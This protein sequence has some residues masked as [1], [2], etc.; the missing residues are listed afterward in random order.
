MRD[1]ARATRIFDIQRFSVHDGPGIRTTVFVAGCP[2][3]CAWCQNPE[4]FADASRG[5]PMTPEEVLP[6]LLA[7]R[8]YYGEDGGVTVSGGEPMQRASWVRELLGLAKGE[9]LHTVVQT[10]GAAPR[11][12]FEALL[13]RVDI[14]QFDLKHMSDARHRALTGAGVGVIHR[15]AAFLVERGAAVQFRMPVVPGV[16]DDR[17][18]VGLVGEFV[19]GLGATSLRLVPYQQTYLPKYAALRLTPRLAHVEP[20]SASDL[21]RLVDTLGRRG[22]H[23]TVDGA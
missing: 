16:N 14:F 13:D 3:R 6:E 9:R 4:S 8:A 12:A 1:D 17:Q 18:N 11:P 7:D 23:V 19:M 20:P 2:L 10:S 5:T 21:A 22:L 15:N